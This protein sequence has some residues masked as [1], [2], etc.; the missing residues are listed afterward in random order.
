ML[1]RV[2]ALELVAHR[3]AW[4][5][6]VL[7]VGIAAMGRWR[8]FRERARVD[9]I[10]RFHAVTGILV[11]A[12]WLLYVWG[13]NAERVVECSLGYFLNPLVNVALG[14]VVLRERLRPWQWTGVALAASGVLYLA[15]RS[16]AVP[17]LALSLAASFGLYGLLKKRAPLGSVDGLFAETL[18]LLL[19]ALAWI[20]WSEAPSSGP[21]RQAV[22][23]EWALVAGTGLVT[24]VPLLMFAAAA[25]RIPLSWMGFL[26]YV[27]P[28][29]Q[30]LIGVLWFREA[31]GPE[32]LHGF[33]L[34]WAG[35][36]VVAID[37][38]RRAVA[39][40]AAG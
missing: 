38:I 25:R 22:A 20:A 32:R 8:R 19:P 27:T 14:V 2:P 26:Q 4:S 11:G 5:A 34:V 36:A 9:G 40:R 28:S 30:F 16:G 6:L 3:V 12:N 13:V 17:W 21:L 31:F 1:H 33:L 15:A 35:L 29:M 10:W 24:T 39:S 37:G 23:L 7:A 18:V